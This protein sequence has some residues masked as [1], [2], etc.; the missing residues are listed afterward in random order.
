MDELSPVAVRR[1]ARNSKGIF[2]FR[3]IRLIFSNENVFPKSLLA[4]K[5]LECLFFYSTYFFSQL[6]FFASEKCH[7][8][9]YNFNF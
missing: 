4:T 8:E 7:R 3:E 9:N 5:C 6:N 2:F 1:R